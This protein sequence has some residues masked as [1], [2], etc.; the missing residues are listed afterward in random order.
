M[1]RSLACLLALLL[2]LSS[3]ALG[4][5]HAVLTVGS[6]AP[7]GEG[8]VFSLDVTL[9]GGSGCYGGSLIL[10]Y[11]SGCLELTEL[12]AGPAVSGAVTAVNP[13]LGDGV[14]KMSWV[15]LAPLAEDGVVARLTFRVLLEENTAVELL[16]PELLDSEGA[17]LPLQTVNGQVTFSTA[18]DPTPETTPGTAAGGSD[19]PDPSGGSDPDRGETAAPSTPSDDPA[20]WENPFRDVPEDAWFHDA[21]AFVHQRG[22]FSG[23]SETT[24]SP[25]LLMD[26]AMLASVLCR[27]EGGVAEVA[28]LDG[29]GD[30]DSIP[31]W[32]APGLAWAVEQEV[33]YG[34]GG[35]L[36]PQGTLTREMLAA[37]LFRYAGAHA[38]DS[39]ALDAFPDGSSVSAWAVDAMTWAV[40]QGL[41]LG[42]EG[43]LLSP[44]AT[45]SRCEVAAILTRF[46]G[47]AEERAG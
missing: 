21:V 9:E 14:A 4:A 1:R 41:L 17:T 18:P 37:M 11:D 8:A 40:E 2:L 13:D 23:T 46:V 43:G 36:M 44:T 34:S 19:Q 16:N 12:T 31:A 10:W 33:L 6:A 20:A 32:A 27:M 29:F 7:V 3:A 39:G 5:E 15:S 35:L 24:F 28:V 47:L 22:L 30:R 45:A 42:R 25:E 38:G 26:R